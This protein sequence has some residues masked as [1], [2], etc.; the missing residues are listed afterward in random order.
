MFL[1]EKLPAIISPP[2][3]PTPGKRW[4]GNRNHQ[5]WSS[6]SH[7]LPVL[8]L[9]EWVSMIYHRAFS[10]SSSTCSIVQC[11]HHPELH[12]KDCPWRHCHS[13]SCK[14]GCHILWLRLLYF[15][16]N[17]FKNCKQRVGL[18]FDLTT[19][20]ITFPFLTGIQLIRK[21]AG[22]WAGATGWI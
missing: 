22:K 9:V 11:F 21:E 2:P 13:E 16:E 17:Y 15:I 7:Q 5:L 12:L 6:D 8:G 18:C 1:S 20:C 14:W 3:H 10:A 19:K 4:G